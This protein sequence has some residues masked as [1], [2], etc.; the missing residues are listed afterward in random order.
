METLLCLCYSSEDGSDRVCPPKLSLIQCSSSWCGGSGAEGAGIQG[1]CVWPV[2]HELQSWGHTGWHHRWIFQAG[3]C[4]W[5]LSVC[6]YNK[7]KTLSLAVLFEFWLSLSCPGDLKKPELFQYGEETMQAWMEG[8]LTDDIVA[9]QRKVEEAE[10]I[11][12][13][14]R[15]HSHLQFILFVITVHWLKI[16]HWPNLFLTKLKG[17]GNSFFYYIS[18]ILCLLV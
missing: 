2:W 12:F 18:T 15:G 9:E 10:L 7:V 16:S 1:H 4:L 5:K 13:Q 14:V 11:I 8:R 3:W 17:R 6:V